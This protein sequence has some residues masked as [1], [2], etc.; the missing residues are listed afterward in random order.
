MRKGQRDGEAEEEKGKKEEGRRGAVCS[1]T[2][3]RSREKEER[4]KG[5]KRDKRKEQKSVVGAISRTYVHI[6]RKDGPALAARCNGP[7]DVL[8]APE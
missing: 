4:A 6:W 8:I 7:I 3:L 2:H 1:S 5:T